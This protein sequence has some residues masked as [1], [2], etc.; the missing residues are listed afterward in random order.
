MVRKDWNKGG[1]KRNQGAQRQKTRRKEEG[2][3]KEKWKERGPFKPFLSRTLPTP[4]SLP[5]SSPEL[6]PDRLGP[7]RPLHRRL[8]P[9]QVGEAGLGLPARQLLA[10]RRRGKLLEGAAVGQGFREHRLVRGARDID[11]DVGEGEALEV[12]GLAHRVG[13]IDERLFFFV[14]FEREKTG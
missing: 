7:R 5:P 10:P 2:K 6:R 13:A 3:K 14:F 11:L 4:H 8:V 12:E 9:L 1:E